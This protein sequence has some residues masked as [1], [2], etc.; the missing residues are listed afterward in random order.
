MDCQRTTAQVAGQT[1]CVAN[2]KRVYLRIRNIGT[3]FV[4]VYYA[5]P[6][7]VMKS[8]SLSA[9][10]E[11]EIPHYQGIVYVAGLAA[12]QIICWMEISSV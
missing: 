3:S 2:P 4:V 1:L 12:P 10:T 11:I 7:D 8:W 9:N 5:L 6:K